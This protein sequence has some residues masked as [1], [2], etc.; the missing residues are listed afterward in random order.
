MQSAALLV[1]PQGAPG[2]RAGGGISPSPSVKWSPGASC[3]RVRAEDSCIASPSICKATSMRRW[4]NLPGQSK[5]EYTRGFE[6]KV[7]ETKF[8][9]RARKNSIHQ[10]WSTHTK[11]SWRN[12]L[13]HLG[14]WGSADP[15]SYS[16]FFI[17]STNIYWA[18]TVCLTLSFPL[19]TQNKHDKV[20]ALFTFWWE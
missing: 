11:L 13:L 4:T 2:S 17:Q 7:L 8:I 12:L 16:F 18:L 15:L 6:D 14:Q 20:P 1:R 10:N 19:R 5:I 9:E 3:A